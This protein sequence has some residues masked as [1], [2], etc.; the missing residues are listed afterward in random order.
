MRTILRV[1]LI[2]LL[3]ALLIAAYLL[4]RILINGEIAEYYC[5]N[6]FPVLSFVPLSIS[7]FFNTS[8]TELFVVIG[9]ITL[10]ILIICFVV[11]LIVIVFKQD[12]RHALFKLY[13][14]LKVVLII[15]IIAALIFEAN[16]GINYNRASVKAQMHLYGDDRSFEEYSEALEW[17]YAGM[18]NARRRLGEDFNGVAHLS[19]NFD[20][21]VYDANGI[22]SAVSEHYDLGM[23]EN[24]IR[25]KAVSLSYLWTY[26]EI[27]GVYDP[28]L[29]EANINTD[30]LDILSFPVTV[31]HEI[32]HV[33]GYAS[34]TDANT[35]AVLSCINSPRA[36]FQYAGYYYIFCRL[37]NTVS[38]Y[39]KAEGREMVQYLSM[40]DME[41]VRRDIRASSRYDQIFES[42]PIADFIASFSEEA[43]NAFLQSNGQADGT[44]TYR[45]PQN[46]FVEYYFRYI[47]DA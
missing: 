31:C 32:S 30:Y 22:V 34:E 14:V 7:S 38:D 4:P 33:K 36:D 42:G 41:M 29:G 40:P 23:S 2:V 20:R 43:N 12:I 1:L 37:Y 44:A 17:A 25:A 35:I 19:T 11:N 5:R 18:I 8:L 3:A 9:S 46:V 26:T 24:Y 13:K 45:V 10:L 47:A 6:I 16:H 27:A 39:A 21:I 15:G 28:F